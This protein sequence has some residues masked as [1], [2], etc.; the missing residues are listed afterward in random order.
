MRS[1]RCND[2]VVVIVVIVVVCVFALFVSFLFL[3]VAIA[4]FVFWG[5]VRVGDLKYNRKK[6][7]AWSIWLLLLAYAPQFFFLIKN[8]PC[9]HNAKCFLCR[10]D[11]VSSVPCICM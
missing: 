6:V 9:A 2:F 11:P 3:S 8:Y 7:T 1:S 5:R 10:P 4:V